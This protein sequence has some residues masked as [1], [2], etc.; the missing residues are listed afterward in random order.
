MSIRQGNNIIAGTDSNGLNLFDFKWADHSL[1]DLN[2]ILSNG[3][4]KSGSTYK[5]MYQHLV[6]DYINGQSESETIASY[7]ITYKLA[8]DGH[9]IVL[10]EDETI[11]NN[12][13]SATGIAWYYILESANSR[14]KLPR[15]K[16]GFTGLRD[17]VGK[18]VPES[19]PNVKGS[20]SGTYGG[21]ID[22]TDSVVSN[23][24]LK[25]TKKVDNT[26]ISGG[27]GQSRYT[28]SID[29]TDSSSVYQDNAPVQQRAT[30]MYLYFY[31]DQ[32]SKGSSSGG[33]GGGSD[34]TISYNAEHKRLTF[35][36]ED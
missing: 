9:K 32:F 11:V 20:V 13:Y 23:G 33:G 16:Y 7:T 30:Q 2:W 19:L 28:L 21:Y 29:A 18:Y 34:V 36:I 35:T 27:S 14:F 25:A 6:E 17:E 4:W 22:A 3:E 31:T 10:P 1:T 26:T 15:T 12:I 5:K 24:A 8:P